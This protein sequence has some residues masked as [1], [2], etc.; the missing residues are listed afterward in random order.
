MMNLVNLSVGRLVPIVAGVD[1]I[2][3]VKNSL[4]EIIG[5]VCI[6]IIGGYLARDLGGGKKIKLLGGLVVGVFVL[7]A[8]GS[9]GTFTD[10]IK[11][12]FSAIT[13]LQWK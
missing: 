10:W 7:A 11:D 9:L 5:A 6:I 12:G 3:N 2:T 4:M 1:V 13:G 8:L